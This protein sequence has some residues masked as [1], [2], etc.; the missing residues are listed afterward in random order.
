MKT[1]VI[2]DFQKDFY[3][4]NEGSLYVNGAEKAV[5]EICNKILN[6]DEK[7]NVVLTL[8]WHRLTDESFSKNGGQWPDHCVQHSLGAAIHPDILNA[9]ATRGLDYQFFLKGNNPSHEEY[10][11]FEH[12][13]RITS[14]FAAFNNL[15]DSRVILY[16]NDD[17]EICGLAGDYCVWETYKNMRKAG[18]KVKPFEEGI[19]WIGEPFDY[20]E[21][22]N[23]C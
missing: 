18:L 15:R 2:V 1:L 4:E 13:I 21:K 19:A 8:D 20:E 17:Y 9:L 7:M 22:F 10:G 5:T 6:S 3:D 23:E 16:N 11:A 12:R 14:G